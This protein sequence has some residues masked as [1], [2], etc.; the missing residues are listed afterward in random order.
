[1]TMM[2]MIDAVAIRLSMQIGI[3]KINN[4]LLAGTKRSFPSKAG[5][6]LL[7]ADLG[8]Q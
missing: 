3:F 6:Y 2:I 8:V 5:Y 7:Y 1:M 4:C